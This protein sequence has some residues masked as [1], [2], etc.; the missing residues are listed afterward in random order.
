MRPWFVCCLRALSLV[1][2]PFFK[3]YE[4]T[5]TVVGLLTFLGLIVGIYQLPGFRWKAIGILSALCALTFVALVRSQR[6]LYRL[7]NELGLKVVTYYSPSSSSEMLLETQPQNKLTV[8]V[9][10]KFINQSQVEMGIKRFAVVLY[11]KRV[12]KP[13]F[14]PYKGWFQWTRYTDP[15]NRAAGQPISVIA[16]NITIKAKEE[17][18]LSIDV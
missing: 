16:E 2:S 8:N 12:L 4:R 3:A 18:R 7:K 13:E 14:L 15:A 9:D 5:I 11:R 10:M 6:E 1:A 17:R